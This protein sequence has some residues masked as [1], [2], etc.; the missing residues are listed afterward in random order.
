MID[1]RVDDILIGHID[2]AELTIGDQ[3]ELENAKG[4]RDIVAWLRIHAGMD[5]DAEA[6]LVKMPLRKIKE[7]GD[8]VSQAMMAAVELPN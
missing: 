4:A 3:I 2:P 8:G 1:I 7:L 6:K 5:K